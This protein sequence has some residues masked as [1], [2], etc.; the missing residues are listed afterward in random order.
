MCA[1]TSVPVCAC[2]HVCVTVY[3]CV[4]SVKFLFVSLGL[5]NGVWSVFKSVHDF[6]YKFVCL[7]AC[8]LHICKYVNVSVSV[9]LP[10]CVYVYV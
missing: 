6:V 8:E 4:V 7:Y 10:A 9:Y 5:Y 1:Y 2:I 3:V